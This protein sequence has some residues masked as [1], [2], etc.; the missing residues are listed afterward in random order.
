[1][2]TKHKICVVTTKR[3][4]SET[5]GKVENARFSLLQ[6]WKSFR[7]HVDTI[8]PSILGWSVN[9]EK[10]AARL[11]RTFVDPSD[12]PF[13]RMKSLNFFLWIQK[14]KGFSQIWSRLTEPARSTRPFWFERSSDEVGV[15]VVKGLFMTIHRSC[16]RI[17]KSRNQS[18]ENQNAIIFFWRQLWLRRLWPSGH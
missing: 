16:M 13:I 9:T 18:R 2:D 3:A 17:L 15:P 8:R 7:Y 12:T 6:F 5:S 14:K 11:T 1:M 10:F 4:A